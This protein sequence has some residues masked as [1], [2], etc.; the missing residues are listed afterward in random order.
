MNIGELRSL[1]RHIELNQSR[2]DVSYKKIGMDGGVTSPSL[3][4]GK[5]ETYLSS[6][7]KGST[8]ECTA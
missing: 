8:R 4:A 6:Y 3:E 2:M 7:R 5:P 1:L